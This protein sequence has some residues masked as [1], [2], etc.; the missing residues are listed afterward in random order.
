MADYSFVSGDGNTQQKRAR[1]SSTRRKKSRRKA[2]A[3]DGFDSGGEDPIL[4]GSSDS[5]SDDLEMES[6]LE[7]E[8][9]V[10]RRSRA[11]TLVG[12]R[13][14]GDRVVMSVDGTGMEERDDDE[15]VVLTKAE[16][17]IAD[18]K[19]LRE[20]AISGIFVGLWY[21]FSLLISIVSFAHCTLPVMLGFFS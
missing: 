20:I 6:F 4:G 1:R 9:T 3:D 17:K 21:I 12:V 2:A 18:L 19:V 10:R 13:T 16:R 5:D 15:P 7:G 11:G 8:S 14:M